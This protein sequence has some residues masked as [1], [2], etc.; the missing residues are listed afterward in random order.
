ME[1]GSRRK[2]WYEESPLY[3]KWIAE[4]E[5]E[6]TQADIIGFLEARFG[7]VPEVVATQVRSISD[8]AALKEAIKHAA[9]SKSIADFRKRIASG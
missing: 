9:K 6:N 3:Q 2:T 5:R 7:D 1:G 4:N 8:L